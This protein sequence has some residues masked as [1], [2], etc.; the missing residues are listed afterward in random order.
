[1]VNGNTSELIQ[2]VS[3]VKRSFGTWWDVIGCSGYRDLFF[4]IEI[5][6]TENNPCK[7]VFM[8]EATEVEE[9]NRILEK[10]VPQV[11]MIKY[12]DTQNLTKYL[13][14]LDK[15]DFLRK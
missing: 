8:N 14:R 12:S 15:R 7:I 3:I 6:K 9:G 4:N 11:K 5:N 1:M 13:P 10:V 2:E